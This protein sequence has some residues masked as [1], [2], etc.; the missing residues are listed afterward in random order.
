MTFLS[1]AEIVLA[2]ISLEKPGLKERNNRR[3][4]P[5]DALTVARYL[6]RARTGQRTRSSSMSGPTK[7]DR[8]LIWNDLGPSSKD[9]FLAIKL[10]T[11]VIQT[12]LQS[13]AC[14]RVVASQAWSSPRR[15]AEANAK[16]KTVFRVKNLREAVANG[17]YGPLVR[18]RRTKAKFHLGS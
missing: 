6:L 5:R 17:S 14:L 13:G 16:R 9:W 18:E 4:C 3:L 1:Q 8:A 15:A 7:V 2:Q 10:G 11:V 12:E